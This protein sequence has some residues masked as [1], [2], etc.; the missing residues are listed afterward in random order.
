VRRVDDDA[1]AR[2]NARVVPGCP[3]LKPEEIMESEA[4]VPMIV[5]GTTVELCGD[6][7]H[8]DIRCMR[9]KNH[10]GDHECYPPSRDPV[11]WT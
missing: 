10:D 11:R 4:V 8:R 1:P 6:E 7:V 3:D 2:A 9:P 5:E